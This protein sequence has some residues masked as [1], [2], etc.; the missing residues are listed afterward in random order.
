MKSNG[1]GKQFGKGNTL[2]P[3]NFKSFESEMKEDHPQENRKIL[4]HLEHHH[5]DPFNKL[6][7]TGI[8]DLSSLSKNT[9]G[10]KK[11]KNQGYF[12]S[13]PQRPFTARINKPMR[14]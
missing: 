1:R 12:L 2:I 7:S 11:K 14:K 4:S 13:N 9:R 10:G 3:S 8:R 5:E 6:S